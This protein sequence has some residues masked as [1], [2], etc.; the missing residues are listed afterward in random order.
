MYPEVLVLSMKKGV[1]VSAWIFI[2]EK[3]QMKASH[4]PQNILWGTGKEIVLGTHALHPG[5]VM[6]SKFLNLLSF[7]CKIGV[8]LNIK[9]IQVSKAL[10]PAFSISKFPSP[11]IKMLMM[12]MMQPLTTHSILSVSSGHTK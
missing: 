5:Y 2:T 9:W 1:K 10:R 7:F 12:M 4:G 8:L 6:S 3:D 11:S